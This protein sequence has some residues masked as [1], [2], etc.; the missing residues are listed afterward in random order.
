M[1]HAASQGGNPNWELN[2]WGMTSR[3]KN[4]SWSPSDTVPDS[5]TQETSDTFKSATVSPIDH[6]TDKETTNAPSL[7]GAFDKKYGTVYDTAFS[8]KTATVSYMEDETYKE[9]D[10]SLED[11]AYKETAKS[12]SRPALAYFDGIEVASTAPPH[13][14][15]NNDDSGLILTPI[16]KRRK[17]R[18]PLDKT[19][20]NGRPWYRK[21]T[22]IALLSALVVIV[23]IAAVLGG[24]LASRRSS[25]GPRPSQDTSPNGA[26]SSNSSTPS[27]TTSA[28]SLLRSD[29]A[30]A[31]ISF[32]DTSNMVQYRLYYQDPSNNIRESSWNASGGQWYES[33]PSISNRAKASTPL[34]AAVVSPQ[35]LASDTS[36]FGIAKNK[37]TTPFTSIYFLDESNTIQ[38]LMTADM[39]ANWKNGP[40]TNQKIV[41]N[42][43]S[44][45]SAIYHSR[46]PCK[47]C[48][49]TRVLVYQDTKNQLQ[50]LNGTLDSTD[51]Q[52]T[53]ALN[54]SAADSTGIGITMRWR[55]DWIPGLRIYYQTPN[56]DA[57]P[58]WWEE[59]PYWAAQNASNFSTPLRPDSQGWQNRETQPLG[60]VPLVSEIGIFT[61]PTTL[62]NSN[63]A[64]M[65]ALASGPG[66]LTSIPWLGNP[67][68][69]QWL[70]VTSPGVFTNKVKVGSKVDANA[71]GH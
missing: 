13:S 16:L 7:W 26:G 53:Y 60:S 24:I 35:D 49:N 18:H 56:G 58:L 64:L 62:S 38:E 19:S 8:D 44:R 39:G 11:G 71:D 4:K 2:D 25:N 6:G 30:I 67:D 43:G 52:S 31:A 36:G 28:A 3:T 65:L 17:Q 32:V 5:R 63:P 54:A 45:L 27:S 34:A 22:I 48:P 46:P 14:R 1:S 21:W 51:S 68:G 57:C 12:P 37:P 55:Q 61:S 70:P 29:S 59:P 15:G 69:G 33:N 20:G 42:A 66:P 50:L 47:N 23:T 41:T 10:R 9:A 40:L